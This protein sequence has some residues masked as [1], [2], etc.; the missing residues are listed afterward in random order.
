MAS[1]ALRQDFDA[2]ISLYKDFIKTNAMI[3]PT[4]NVSEAQTTYKGK[5]KDGKYANKRGPK[6]RNDDDDPEEEDVED[7]YYSSKEYDTLMKGQKFS[8]KKK[9]EGRGSKR[10]K[11][12]SHDKRIVSMKSKMESMERNISKLVAE[13]AKVSFEDADDER[14]DSDSESDKK[15]KKN[16][17]HLAL[18]RQKGG[19]RIRHFVAVQTSRRQRRAQRREIYALKENGDD[20]GGRTKTDSHANTSVVSKECLGFHDFERPVN[21]SGFDSSLGT[22]N[23]RSVVSAALAYDD[24]TTG[25]VIIVVIHQAIYIPTMDHNILCP[26]L[27]MNEVMIDDCPKF[28][29]LNLQLMEHMLSRSQART[30]KTTI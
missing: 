27:R 5:P 30:V 23:D 2:C 9:R 7:R 25:E 10:S 11:T 6:R 22:V 15:K 29:H 28:V 12:G 24:P 13:T 20:Q 19:M 26:I 14:S 8:L 18:T 16:R 4:F 3:N 17:K 21:V 1:A